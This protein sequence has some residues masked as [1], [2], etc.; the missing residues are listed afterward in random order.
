[1]NYLIIIISKKYIFEFLSEWYICRTK[2]TEN[3]NHTLHCHIIS[4]FLPDGTNRG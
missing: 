2:K 4:K 1:M 3:G